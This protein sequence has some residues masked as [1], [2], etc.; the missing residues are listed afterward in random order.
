M[1]RVS[2][3]CDV[4]HAACVTSASIGSVV[5]AQFASHLSGAQPRHSL[6]PLRRGVGD[7]SP[8]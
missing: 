3:T 6:S 5:G 1:M 8:T 4:R 2:S 7:L